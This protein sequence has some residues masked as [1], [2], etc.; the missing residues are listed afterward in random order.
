MEGLTNV[1]FE[2][3]MPQIEKLNITETLDSKGYVFL[4]SKNLPIP[5]ELLDHQ[6]QFISSWDNLQIDKFMA[7]SGKYRMRRYGRFTY[8]Q[9]KNFL[10]N[11]KEVN[12]FQAR[13]YNNLNG[14]KIRSFASLSSGMVNN[15][16]LHYLIRFHFEKLPLTME[17]S[18]IN[19]WQVGIHQ[20]RIIATPGA[21]GKPTPEGIHKDGELYTVQHIIKRKNVTGGAMRV[22]DNDKE[23]VDSWEQ[24][25]L[26]DTVYIKDEAGYHDV[27][28]I[29]SAD[30]KTEGIRDILLIDFH[31]Y[32]DA[33][34]C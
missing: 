7:D 8:D 13:G 29:I 24:E 33:I 31:P 34:K 3:E 27:T 2:A 23:L 6:D 17:Q 20:I 5:K 1:D 15:K 14:D 19:L 4:E 25:N 18:K 9:A 21:V 10:I 16:L 11:Q 28:P 32:T 30:G 22:F 12:Y 26:F